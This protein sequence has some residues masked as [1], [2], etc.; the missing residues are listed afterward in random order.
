MTFIVAGPVDLEGVLRGAFGAYWLS[1]FL[2]L[3]QPKQLLSLLIVLRDIPGD[4]ARRCRAVYLIS[5]F[6]DVDLSVCE[7][8]QDRIDKDGGD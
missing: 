5:C 6:D 2:L 3:Q 7:K 1:L 8:R 4:L